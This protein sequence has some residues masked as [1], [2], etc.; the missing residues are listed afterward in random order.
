MDPFTREPL[1]RRAFHLCTWPCGLKL[2]NWRLVSSPFHS[3]LPAM[4][5]QLGELEAR[6]SAYI[7]PYSYPPLPFSIRTRETLHRKHTLYSKSPDTPATFRT[8]VSSCPFAL[9][10]HKFV[11]SFP[12]RV[13]L[14]TLKSQLNAAKFT[15]SHRVHLITSLPERSFVFVKSANHIT[16]SWQQ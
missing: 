6:V 8:L 11:P 16:I 9:P 12:S 10:L 7:I 15:L 1:S 5:H 3:F 4:W 14:C 13:T 2:G